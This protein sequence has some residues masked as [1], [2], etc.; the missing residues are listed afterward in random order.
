MGVS[1]RPHLDRVKSVVQWLPTFKSRGEFISTIGDLVPIAKQV[2]FFTK[3][4]KFLKQFHFYI[5][6]KTIS[7][8]DLKV[9]I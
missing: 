7:E 3:I 5:T 2:I 8:I 6:I 1:G 4:L 9:E